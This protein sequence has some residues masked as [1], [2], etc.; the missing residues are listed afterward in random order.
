MNQFRQLHLE[1]FSLLVL[2]MIIISCTP[3]IYIPKQNVSLLDN[4]FKNSSKDE[5]A[6]SQIKDCECFKIQ[7]SGSYQN[8][9]LPSSKHVANMLNSDM[10]FSVRKSTLEY[11]TK[12]VESVYF[13]D[14]TTGFAS[15]S[16]PPSPEFLIGEYLPF[17]KDNHAGGTDIF[18]F[19]Q[20]YINQ[21]IDENSNAKQIYF[22]SFSK[23][24]SPFWDSHPSAVTK[25]NSKNQCV[26]LLIFSSDRESP[27]SRAITLTGDTIYGGSTDL[28]YTFGKTQRLD[29]NAKEMYRYDW[30]PVRKLEGANTNQFNEG[31][32]FV[33]CQCC[34]PTLFFSSNRSNTNSLDFDLYAVKLEIDFENLSLRTTTEPELVDVKSKTTDSLTLS[35]NTPADERFPFIPFPHKSKS[36]ENNIYFSSDRNKKPEAKPCDCERGNDRTENFGGYDIYRYQ[37]PAKYSCTQPEE[38]ITPPVYEPKLFADITI[39]NMKNISDTIISPRIIIK[40]D[41]GE[42]Y[43]TDSSRIYVPL[44][45]NKKYYV[46]GGSS[47]RSFECLPNSDVIF[48]GYLPT[49]EEVITKNM[50]SSV[51]I[52]YISGFTMKA[53]EYLKLNKDSVRYE[54]GILFLKGYELET[55]DK[56][57]TIP[58]NG[59]I[60]NNTVYYDNQITITRY[61]NKID[62]V[63]IRYAQATQNNIEKVLSNSVFSVKTLND[64]Y[65]AAKPESNSITVIKDTI[66]LMPDE[67]IKPPCYC[68]FAGVLT[69]YQQNVPYFQTGY[70]EVNTLKNYRRDLQRLESGK[71]SDAKW[72]EL[73]KNNQYFGE[74]LAGRFA[75]FNEYES[76]ARTV[77]TN[78]SK[79]AEMIVNNIIPVFNAIDSITPGGKLIISLDAW[80]D[81]RPVKRGWYIGDEINYTEGTLIEGANFFDVKFQKVNL[82]NKSSLNLNNDTLSRLRAYFGYRE[83]LSK[84]LDTTNIGT[85]FYNYYKQG[86]VLLPDDSR[87]TASKMK[88]DFN[89]KEIEDMVKN[90]KIILLAKGNYFDPTEFKIPRY[91]RDVDSS[92]FMLDTIRRIDVRINTLQYENGVLIKSPCCNESIPCVDFQKKLELNIRKVIFD[93]RK[94]VKSRKRLK[95]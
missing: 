2:S 64:E 93:D 58:V 73:H 37:L 35:I 71:F 25:N 50:D 14:S 60:E 6:P 51:K 42:L 80:S 61:W 78:I 12:N 22:R 88:S 16:H 52:E 75:R 38:P 39:I 62:V 79:M 74:G 3:K 10:E 29:T 59:R 24:N 31:S 36:E 15:F 28:Y 23:V 70:W 66:Y 48:R 87:L 20:D 26:T 81:R 57:R 34:D 9:V 46:S 76:Y 13:I 5:I 72:I 86:L 65:Y 44:D 27:F 47:Y 19:Y 33:Y 21:P 90:S 89:L 17:E 85:E 82:I 83:L 11:M 32:P 67:L 77:D 8:Q 63:P 7:D 49:D 53:D 41:N 55:N 18:F 69:S 92:L 40:D 54:K 84:L 30:T 94:Q 43:S 56:I 68:E 91:I 95:K 1:F 45:F 4:E